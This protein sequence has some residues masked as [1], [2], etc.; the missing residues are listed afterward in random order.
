MIATF[1]A[2]TKVRESRSETGLRPRAILA[3]KRELCP[4]VQ[5]PL[6][7]TQTLF[8]RRMVIKLAPRIA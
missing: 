5:T 4:T 2:F 6:I 1:Q 8:T 3:F 7:G